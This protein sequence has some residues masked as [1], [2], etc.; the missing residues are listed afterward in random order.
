MKKLQIITLLAVFSALSFMQGSVPA[1]VARFTVDPTTCVVTRDV[2]VAGLTIK[3]I[4]VKGGAFTMGYRGTE[5]GTEVS[6]SGRQPGTTGCGTNYESTPTTTVYYRYGSETPAHQVTVSDFYIGQF[7]V[8]QALWTAVMSASD[9]GCLPVKVTDS[10]KGDGVWPCTKPTATYGGNGKNDYPAYYVNWFEC[11][12][13]IQKLNCLTG[14]TFRMP[15]EAEWEYA[16]RGGEEDAPG[17]YVGADGTTLIL[18]SVAWYT[19]NSGGSSHPVGGKRPNELGIYDMSGNIWEWCSDQFNTY[20]SAPQ[21]NPPG[22]S[23]SLGYDD[24]TQS[25]V[26][27]GILRVFRGG[28]WNSIAT[29]DRV[30]YRHSR[31]PSFRIHD[32]GLRLVLVA[33]SL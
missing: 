11:D 12:T 33:P 28:G 5:D 15:T 14:L 30:T 27:S 26:D 32:I 6:A 24:G 13:F 1:D 22:P 2:S 23:T 3:M 31:S 8:T 19:T 10:A 4:P 21:T 9:N 29:C 7:E 25:Q 18:D 17:Q 16:A 20:S